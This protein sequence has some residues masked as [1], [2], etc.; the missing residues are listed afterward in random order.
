MSF[1]NSTI[2]IVLVLA[3]AIYLIYSQNQMYDME[4]QYHQMMARSRSPVD[5]DEY[6][7]YSQEYQRRDGQGQ[8]SPQQPQF[9]PQQQQFQ[10]SQQQFQPPQSQFQPQ[11]QQQFPPQPPNITEISVRSPT[12]PFSDAIKKQDLYTMY[13][14]LTYPQLRLPREV[15]ERYNDYYKTTGTYPPFNE[16]TQP[17]LFDNPIMNGFLVKI[18]DDCDVPFVDNI[19]NSVPLFR[20]QSSR[21]TN[22]YFYY[23]LD[24]R[25][26]NMLIQ[27][28]IPLDNVKI[29]GVRILNADFYGLPEI[30]DHDVIEDISIYPGAKFKVTLYKTYHFP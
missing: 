4:S 22:R 30:Y 9:Q 25:N 20:V 17:F 3:L 28:K 5:R 10:P 24:N 19:P 2:I 18:V 16:A 27:P 15:L 11:S 23:V 26:F 21:N 6:K 12:D 7:K 13:D 8:M 14:P 1:P 29:N